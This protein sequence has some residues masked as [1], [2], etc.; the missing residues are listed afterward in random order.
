MTPEPNDT[1]PPET[2]TEAMRAFLSGRFVVFDGPDGSGKSTQFRRFSD[3][4]GAQGVRVTEVREPGGT[5]I[6]PWTLSLK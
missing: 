4:A 5:P 6:P 1:I 2:P 3:W